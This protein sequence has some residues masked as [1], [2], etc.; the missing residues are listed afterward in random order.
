MDSE[1]TNLSAV[2]GI[3]QALTTSSDVQFAEVTLTSFVLD[4]NTISGVDDSGD[5]D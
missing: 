4:G 1:C 5:V 2:K 3:N